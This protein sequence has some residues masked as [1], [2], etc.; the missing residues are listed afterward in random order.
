[1]VQIQQNTGLSNNG[2]QKLGSAL[3]QIIPVRLVEPSFPL[4]FAQAGQKL[5]D[6]F[7]ISSITLAENKESCQVV[8][9]QSLNSL[10]EAFK[11]AQ[12]LTESAI[13]KLGI[14]GGGS[15]LKVSFTHIILEEDETP[16]NSPVQ[17]TIKQ[18][19][20]PS[21]KSTSVKQQILIVLAQ[22]TPESYHN[23]KATLNL[24]QVQEECQK[25]SAIISCDLKL[26]NILCG[27]Q[28][29]SSMHPCCWC[30]ASSR[31]F[32]NCGRLRTFGEIRRQHSEFIRAGGD[33]RKSKDFKNVVHLPIFDFPDNKLLEASHPWSF[34]C[35]LVW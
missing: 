34:I 10:S 23:V 15:F 7:I 13:L 35:Y 28:S 21:T 26:A 33:L 31:N 2:M 4:K 29:H 16:P 19:P 18:M 6:Q 20:P 3:N 27:I 32:Q 25:D 22:N 1:M 5:N 14:N 8:H 17:K 12:K 24:I 30:D 11:S 9:C